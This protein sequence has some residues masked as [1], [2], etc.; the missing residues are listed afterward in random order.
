MSKRNTPE[1][2]LPD[3]GDGYDEIVVDIVGNVD[4]GKSSLCGILSHP[5]LRYDINNIQ[6]VLDDGNGSARARVLAL[7]HEQ[8]SGRT[9]SISYNYM[10]FDKTEPRPRIVSLVDLAGHEQYL[11]TTITG[12]ISSY[13]EHGL[14][15]IAKNITQM[16]REHYAILAS[17]GIPVLFVLTKT[18]IIPEHT[19]TDNIKRIGILAKKYGKTVAPI[20]NSDDI[21]SC[22]NDNKVFG[23]IKVS[24]KNGDGLP[25]L[26]NYISQIRHREKE[27]NLIKG[28]AIDRVYYNITGFGMVVAGIT[29]VDVK[30]GSSMFMGPFKGNEFIPVKIRSI[31]NDYRHFVDTLTSGVRGCLCVRFDDKYKPFLRMGMVI[32][33]KVSDVNSVKKFHAHVAIFRGK[34]SNIRVGFNSYI[35]IGLARGGIKFNRFR[36]PE[37]KEDVDGMIES[38]LTLVD[39]EFMTHHNTINVNDR[40]LF[41]S[42]RVN[43]LG[44]VVSITT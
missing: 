13:P 44:K 32:C 30:K 22:I 26:A 43:G 38:K 3:T 29:G 18:D 25:L 7:Q 10:I 42:G 4:S 6:K 37:T 16:T 11:K 21:K 17:M 19:M 40:F 15:L 36:N 20:E 9:S 24:N 2:K 39:L 41:R 12:V 31:N 33:N 27:K 28:F 14:V 23:Y 1:L 8:K 5:L 34:S 35:N